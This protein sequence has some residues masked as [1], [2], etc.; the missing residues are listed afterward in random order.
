MK[1]LKCGKESKWEFCRECKE[2]KHNAGAMI[3][4]NRT[5]LIKLLM[6][7]RLS[8][9][10]FEKFILYTNNIIKYWKIYMEY[11]WVKEYKTLK[12]ICG[13]VNV[14]SLLIP[15]RSWISIIIVRI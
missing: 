3:S 2:I 15:V 10:W 11:Q 1:C 12:M 13:A 4:Q 8:P 9:P 14:A 6:W 5:K 7:K